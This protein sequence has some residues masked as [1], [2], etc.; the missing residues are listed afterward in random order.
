MRHERRKVLTRYNGEE[1][2]KR[3]DADDDGGGELIKDRDA[4]QS[5]REEKG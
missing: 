2:R 5:I 1:K 4:S 3:E